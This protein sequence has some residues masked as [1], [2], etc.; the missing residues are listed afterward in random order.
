MKVPGRHWLAIKV[1]RYLGSPPSPQIGAAGEQRRGECVRACSRN[2]P[3]IAW[4]S[5][6]QAKSG[7]V[8][9]AMPFTNGCVQ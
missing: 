9:Q 4:L 6:A 1:T 7:P 5:F 3:V 2:M 8:E